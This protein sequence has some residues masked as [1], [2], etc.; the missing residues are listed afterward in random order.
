MIIS[1]NQIMQL[2]NICKDFMSILVL[3][4]EESAAHKYNQIRDLFDEISSQQSKELNLAKPYF[5]LATHH[6]HE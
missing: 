1:D 3:S 6:E 4:H 2:L 5:T